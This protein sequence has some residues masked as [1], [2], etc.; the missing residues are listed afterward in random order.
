M[1]DDD[2]RPGGEPARLGWRDYLAIFIAVLQ[3]IGLPMLV[4]ILVI[5]AVLAIGRLLG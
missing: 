5:L 4:L 2:E 1:S 3:T